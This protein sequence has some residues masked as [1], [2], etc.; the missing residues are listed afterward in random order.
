MS[1]SPLLSPR[2]SSETLSHPPGE[3]RGVEMAAI[4]LRGT[5][6]VAESPAL[7][8][9]SSHEDR[10]GGKH[11]EHPVSGSEVVESEQDN[12]HL[13]LLGP[14]LQLQD[15][16][17]DLGPWASAQSRIVQLQALQADLHGAAERVDALVAFG[18]G[19]AQRSEPQAL[20]SLEKVVRTLGAHRDSIFWRLW[21]LQAQ[22]V[23]SSLVF[24]EADTLD[25]DLEVEGDSDGPGVGGIWGPWAPSS[26][27]SPAELEWDPAGDIGGV[28]PL[29]RKM[30]WTPGAP[31]EL[32]GYRRL[33]S[34]GQGLED[35]LRSGLNH[36]KHLA[37]HQRHSLLQKTQTKKQHRSPRLQEMQLAVAP[38]APA[39]RRPLIF[40]ILILFLLLV[41]ATML[42]PM[43]GDPCC[44]PSRLARAPY[45]VLSYVNGPPPL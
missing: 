19:L 33:Q 18:E 27:P 28:R 22:L 24:E 45:L 39:I 11:H 37:G 31:C 8:A 17:Y 14:G 13:C 20:A 43:T 4:R 12:L 23:S 10:V 26:L 9:P 40:L 30:A 25:Q 34:R 42:L 38:G 21:Q 15:L 36:R 32:C 44:S 1:L 7:P 35:L 6:P 41:G 5:D 3:P 29:G 16:E 2:P